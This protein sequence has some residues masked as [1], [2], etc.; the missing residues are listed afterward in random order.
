MTQ[1]PSDDALTHAM[2]QVLP[3]ASAAWV[4]GSAVDPQ[5]FVDASDIDLAV[6]LPQALS[7]THKLDVLAQL[8]ALLGREVDLLDF[9][10]LDTVMQA[11]VLS[12]GRLLFSDDA[13][14]LAHYCA[15]VYSE[16]Q[17]IQRWRQPLMNS[18]A[19]RLTQ[20]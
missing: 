2:R 10:R 19:Q 13:V 4:F 1:L 6:M 9:A 3:Q 16:Y 7:S 11:Q 20:P 5:R 15:F 17:D 12:T 18:L 14:A 8:A